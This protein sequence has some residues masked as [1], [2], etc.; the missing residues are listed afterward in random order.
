[1]SG[2]TLCNN[3]VP[4]AEVEYYEDSYTVLFTKSTRDMGRAYN[5]HR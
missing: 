3:T 4:S 2:P 1:M 5:M